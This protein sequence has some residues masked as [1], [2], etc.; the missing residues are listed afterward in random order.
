MS[1]YKI[2]VPSLGR[3]HLM[4]KLMALLPDAIVTVNESS[5]GEYYGSGVPDEQLLPHPD[6]PL[7][8]TRNWIMDNVEA[9]CLIMFNDDLQKCVK[10]AHSSKTI[11][12]AKMIQ[13]II[14]NTMQCAIDLD[15]DVFCWSLTS[16]FSMLFPEVRPFRASAPMSTHAWGVRG[17][18]LK[19]RRFDTKFRGCDDFDYTLETIQR[20]RLLL[21]DVRYHFDCGGMSRARGGESGKQKSDV[22]ATAQKDLRTKWGK[23]CGES[24]TK[25]FIKTNTWRS[26]AINVRRTNNLG[27]S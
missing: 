15:I 7:T 26:F 19:E 11:R 25:N 4:P 5:I 3:P 21:C 20:D 17:K 12:N 13:Q 6:L 18:A 14:R 9:D 10:I 1:N 22:L 23:Y 27:A 2:V 24:A 16:N 8:E